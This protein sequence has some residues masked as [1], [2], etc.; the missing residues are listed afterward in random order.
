MSRVREF[1]LKF[2]TAC[3]MMNFTYYSEFHIHTVVNLHTM[4]DFTYYGEFHIL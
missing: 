4:V 3:T 2:N 1:D